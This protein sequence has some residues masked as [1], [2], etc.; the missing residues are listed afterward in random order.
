MSATISHPSI[1]LANVSRPLRFGAESGTSSS[2]GEHS[3]EWVLKRNCSTTPQQ[4]VGFY[5]SLCLVSF[6]I[7][8]GF[9][10]EGATLVMP[11]AS[12][13]ILAVGTALLIYSRHATDS[14][15]IRLM[16]GR[17]TVEH[18]SG[19]RVERVEFAPAWVRVE[20]EHGDRSLIELS[21]Q[22]RRISVGR[23]TR[24]ELRRQL[25]KNCVGLCGAGSGC[26]RRSKTNTKINPK[27]EVA[28]MKTMKALWLKLKPIRAGQL[29]ITLGALVMSVA[30]RAVNDLP[31][32]PSVNGIDLPPAV[33]QIAADQKWLH[34]FMLWIC[35]IIFLGVFGVMFYSIFKHRNRRAR[36]PRTSTRAPRSRSSGPSCRSSS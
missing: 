8:A 33:T 9:W 34:Y 23:F 4:M 12:I 3:V 28:T 5:A 21:G 32:G 35:T 29:G 31:G 11:F 1:A 26:R 14:E 36:R 24:P 27:T 15:S 19:G 6:A 22:G 20:P 17:L 25:P 18:A 16:P 7:A 2:S 10:F 13:E 30:A